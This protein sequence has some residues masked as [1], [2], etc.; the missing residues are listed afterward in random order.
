MR[1]D[2]AQNI[3]LGDTVYNCFMDTLIVTSIYNNANVIIFSTID[4]RLNRESYDSNDVYLADLDGESDD[5]KSWI[6]WA[7]ENR[8]FFNIFDHIETMKEIYKIGFCNGFEYKKQTSFE[9][10]MQK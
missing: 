6:N 3:K 4:T 9:E 7:K 5:E 1:N 10:Q 2:L 8:D